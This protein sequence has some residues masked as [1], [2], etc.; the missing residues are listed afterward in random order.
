MDL[1][2]KGKNALVCGSSGGIGKA[3]AEQ[4]AILGAN[5]MLM[6]RRET[7]L[8]ESVELLER[9]AGQTHGYLVA[10][11]DEL[12]QFTT[13]IQRFVNTNNTVHI[14]INNSGGPAPGLIMEATPQ[15]FQTALSRH[16]LCY[17]TLVQNLLPGMQKTKYGRIVNIISTSVKEPHPGLGVSNTM[18]AAVANWG[19]TLATEIAPFGITVNN[20]LPGA[21]DTPRL[22]T[23]FQM[24]AK[25]KGKTPEEITSESIAKIPFGRFAQPEEVASAVAFLCSPAASFITGINLPVDGGRTGSL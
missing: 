18:R 2:L 9:D 13:T 12:D 20:V 3:C 6:A 10:D 4:L 25:K 19:K 7:V 8:Q 21:T 11:M 5:V 24:M 22:K 1:N 17:Q 16:V 14:L 15:E 23:V